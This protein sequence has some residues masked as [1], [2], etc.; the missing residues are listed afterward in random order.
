MGNER[1]LIDRI[2]GKLATENTPKETL[3]E[4]IITNVHNILHW[5]DKNNVTGEA[6]SNPQSDSQYRNWE[7]PVQNWWAQNRGRY[8]T[9]TLSQIPTEYDNIHTENLKP[10]ITITA[11]DQEKIHDMND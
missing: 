6:P 5:V 9:T 8:Q 1:V 10:K 11:P 7:I 3:T 4:K 2:S